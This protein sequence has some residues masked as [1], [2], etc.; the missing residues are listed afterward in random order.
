MTHLSE[1][2]N[3]L[4]HF[5]YRFLYLFPCGFPSQRHPDAAFE[6]LI[7]QADGLEHMAG[8]HASGSAGTPPGNRDTGQIQ[9]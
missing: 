8:L 7:L 5:L 6:H 9:P 2:R 3:D 4:R 1:I